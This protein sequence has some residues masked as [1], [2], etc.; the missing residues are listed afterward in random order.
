MM[1]TTVFLAHFSRQGKVRYWALSMRN[2]F[3]MFLEG[4]KIGI[5]V[6]SCSCSL[7]RDKNVA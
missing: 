7:R 1:R 3:L 2:E 4:V 6:G 5:W